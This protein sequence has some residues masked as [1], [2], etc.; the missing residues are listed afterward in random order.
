MARILGLIIDRREVGEAGAFDGLT[1][2]ELMERA[3]KKAE[4]LGVPGPP[5][6]VVDNDEDDEKS[7]VA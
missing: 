4:E 3:T 6:L 5:R 1:D 7:G 2:A